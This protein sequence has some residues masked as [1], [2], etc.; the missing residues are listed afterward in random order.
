MYAIKI[1]YMMSL[2]YI[3]KFTCFGLN[4]RTLHSRSDFKRCTVIACVLVDIVYKL[5]PTFGS[6]NQY[7]FEFVILFIASVQVEV[8][9]LRRFSRLKTSPL[10]TSKYGN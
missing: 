2:H 7:S 8:G 10:Y 5:S 6:Q 9:F 4:S 3:N 1:N